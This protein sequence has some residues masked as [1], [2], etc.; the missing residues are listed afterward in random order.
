MQPIP[1]AELIGQGMSGYR[2]R[3]PLSF[4]LDRE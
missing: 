1:V 4:S 2:V 3:A